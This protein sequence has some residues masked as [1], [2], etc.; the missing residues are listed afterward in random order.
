MSDEGD[1]RLRRS[2]G[3]EPNGGGAITSEVLI[4]VGTETGNAEA[5]AGAIGVTLKELGFRPSVVH[6]EDAGLEAFDGTRGV[7]ICTST[8]GDG[9]LPINAYDLH[10][11]LVK[12]Q[13]NLGGLVFAVCAL[14]DSIYPDFCEAGKIW[15]LLLK[16][17]G[18][19]EA[20]ERYEADAGPTEENLEGACEWAEQAAEKFKEADYARRV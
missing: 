1:A 7:I 9:E 3:A 14:G 15:S 2:L 20:V 11:L 12:G 16:E 4:L 19:R 10:D 8:Y 6:M 13:P 18:A 5:F 17:L